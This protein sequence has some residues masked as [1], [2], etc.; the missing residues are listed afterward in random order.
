MTQIDAEQK[1]GRKLGF[2]S[3]WLLAQLVFLVIAGVWVAI[4]TM[5]GDGYRI[6]NLALFGLCALPPTS[7]LALWGVR[8]ALGGRIAKLIFGLISTAAVI[9]AVWF[10][11]HDAVLMASVVWL[12]TAVP[13]FLISA[14]VKMIREKEQAF[15]ERRA[16]R[17]Q[18][19]IYRD[20]EVDEYEWLQRQTSA[21]LEHLRSKVLHAAD[22]NFVETPP[23]P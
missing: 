17:T 12:V 20:E 5:V 22:P 8:A 19:H 2:I 9:G 15:A 18:Q 13:F 10:S 23:N 21:H 14:L 4:G 3:T 16:Q 11:K 6:T 7:F 1:P